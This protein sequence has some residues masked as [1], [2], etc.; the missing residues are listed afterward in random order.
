MKTEQLMRQL[1]DSWRLEAPPA[2]GLRGL[3]QRLAWRALAPVL[4]QQRAFN[5]AA[6]KLLYA[7]AERIRRPSSRRS[8]RA[9]R[10]A[11]RAGADQDPRAER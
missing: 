2:A 8:E 10:R 9:A 11:L 7:L 3:A 6:V 1:E 4:A 5:A